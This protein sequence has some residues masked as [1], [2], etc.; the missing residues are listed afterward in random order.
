MIQKRPLRRFAISDNAVVC[1]E[2]LLTPFSGVEKDDPEKYEF[3]F[4]LSQMRIHIEQTFGIITAKWRIPH[5]PLEICLKD[6]GKLIMCITRLHYCIN[7][8]N[9]YLNSIEDTRW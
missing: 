5:Q 6:V 9:T 4:Y 3:S 8:G 7:E 1:S 2:T